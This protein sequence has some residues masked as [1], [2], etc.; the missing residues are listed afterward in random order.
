MPT[1]RFACCACSRSGEAR[2]LI[3][4]L[5]VVDPT[6]RISLEVRPAACS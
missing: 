5:L 3:S 2:D 6:Q 1:P 4:R